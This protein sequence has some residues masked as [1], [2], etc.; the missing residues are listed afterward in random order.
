MCA[1]GD[2][3]ILGGCVAS[4]ADAGPGSATCVTDSDCPCRN[5]CALGVCVRS[6]RCDEAFL[7]W[8]GA[9]S[10]TNGECIHNLGSFNLSWGTTSGGPYPNTLDVGMPCVP[11]AMVACDGGQAIQLD[12]AYRIT[13]L[14]NGTW[15]FVANDCDT[16]GICSTSSN[17]ASKVIHC[18]SNAGCV[19]GADCA[20]Y[21]TCD[22]SSNQCNTGCN[23]NTCS[24]VLDS[25]CNGLSPAEQICG[26]GAICTAG[27]K[28]GAPCG[29][30]QVCDL[31]TGSPGTC[32]TGCTG[33]TC[34]CVTDSQCEGG[35]AI[36][37]MVCGV[38]GFCHAGCKTALNCSSTQVCDTTLGTIGSCSRSCTSPGCCYLDSQCNGGQTGQ[39][40][41][42]SSTNSSCVPGCHQNSDCASNSCDAGI[43][44]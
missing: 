28:D 2:V 20:P 21:Q 37:G 27:C 24:C 18:S 17:Q 4:C 39:G 7:T 22:P 13:G 41:I 35:M 5:F 33:T 14:T 38:D 19:T 15:Y 30:D 9:T 44:N 32:T 31:S 10:D 42:C 23:G 29:I 26:A 11:G 8:N 6:S 34:A 36:S 3:C 12:C 1:A 25:Q 43:C 40:V 16:S